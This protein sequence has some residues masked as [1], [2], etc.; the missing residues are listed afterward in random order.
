[1][2]KPRVLILHADGTNRD[3]DAAQ[4]FEL[5]GAEADIVHLNQLRAGEKQWDDYQ[6][7]AVP[8][9]FSYADALGAGK[10]LALDLNTYFMEE[11]RSFIESGKPVI[12]ICNGFQ[13]LVKSG[14][15]PDQQS[16]I[17]NQQSVS[18]SAA[19]LTFNADGHFECR[20]V[21]LKP[22]SQTCLW[23][24]GLTELIECPIAHG[25]GRFMLDEPDDLAT[26]IALDQ[27][28]L[29]YAQR[30]GTP[31]N[32]EYPINPNGS[33]GDIAGVCNPRGNVLGLMPHPEDHIFAYQ[34]P[35]WTRGEGGHSGL[36][37]FE[38]GVRY[39][40]ET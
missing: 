35:R 4:A 10:L 3:H 15:L 34:H 20:W 36:K 11:V 28:A 19:T 26:L 8:G 16:A 27:I 37:L 38:N 17:S 29:S 23:T 9:G 39:A 40:Q 21:V 31:A 5:A 24:R 12:G 2:L 6:L 7:L 22:Q 18:N 14:I 33:I 13:A 30:D 1:M 32:G 25:E